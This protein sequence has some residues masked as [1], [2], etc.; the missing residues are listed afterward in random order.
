MKLNFTNQ[1]TGLRVSFVCGKW[2]NKWIVEITC[3][4]IA[5]LMGSISSIVGDKMQKKAIEH[6][7]KVS[8]HYFTASGL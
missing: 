4:M 8:T 7:T 2:K 6:A 1:K 3:V 5:F